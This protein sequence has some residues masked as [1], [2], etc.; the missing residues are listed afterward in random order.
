LAANIRIR[1]AIAN[2]SR[3]FAAKGANLSQNVARPN[4]GFDVTANGATMNG[5]SST[6]I[7][8]A[9]FLLNQPNT[10]YGDMAA[11]VGPTGAKG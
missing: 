2:G 10:L 1:P 9:Q 7:R 4:A 5:T 8:S 6:A 11:S 3:G